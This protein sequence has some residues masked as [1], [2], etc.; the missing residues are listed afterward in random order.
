MPSN[1]VSMQKYRVPVPCIDVSRVGECRV[2]ENTATGD[3]SLTFSIPRIGIQ[4]LQTCIHWFEL[5]YI[6]HIS[7]WHRDSTLLD[8]ELRDEMFVCIWLHMT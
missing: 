2:L 8:Q 6:R 4:L 5:Q 1:E 3:T 7:L